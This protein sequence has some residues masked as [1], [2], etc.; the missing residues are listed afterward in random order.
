MGHWVPLAGRQGGTVPAVVLSPIFMVDRLA[1]AATYAGIFRSRDGGSSWEPSNEGLG[2]YMI[3]SIAFSPRYPVDHTLYAGAADGGVYRST[4]SGDKW[5][6]L[7]RLGSGSAVTDLGVALGPGDK[8]VSVLAGTLADGVFFSHDGWEW[9]TCNSA[10]ADLSVIAVGVSPSYN[11]DRTAL[12]A[13]ARGLSMTL[14]GGSKWSQVWSPA[15]DDGVQCIALSPAFAS[16]R[17][18]FAGTERLGVIRSLDGGATWQPANAGLA[19]LCVNALAI[20][21]DFASDGMLVAAT[22]GSVALSADR[23]ES[24]QLLK[25]GSESALSLAVSR[26]SPGVGRTILAGLANDGVIRSA[27]SGKNWAPA[28]EGLHASSLIGMALSPAF[29]ADSTLFAWG[30]S[31]GLLRS[32]DGGQGW[33]VVSAASD[34]GSINA[35]ALS[36]AFDTD[37]TLFAATSAG[38]FASED[39]GTEWQA[40]GLA[41]QDVNLPAL[42]PDFPHDSLIVAATEGHLQLSTDGG[43]NWRRLELPSGE[44]AALAAACAPG[45]D[46]GKQLLLASWREPSRSRRGRLRVWR[47]NLPDSPWTLLFSRDTATRITALAVPDS[48]SQDQQFYIGNGDAVYRTTQGAQERT[49]DG[50]TPLWLPSTIGSRSYPVL[51][52]A[53]SA[54]Y[55]QTH[56]MLA[57]TADGVFISQDDVRSWSKLGTTPGDRG[58][59][60]VALQPMEAGDATAYALSIG[61]QLWKWD[62]QD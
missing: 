47:R 58:A 4:D 3:Q 34:G 42:S 18:A 22:A 50:V 39:G 17:T 7:A 43:A 5:E 57:A 40:R 55:G 51:S 52:L 26:F 27:D 53:A 35:V 61:G 32:E 28:N 41:D 12:A 36:P 14:D 60:A 13:T 33:H 20:S 2:S 46:E 29:E 56:T 62:P 54:N 48:Y 15:G 11:E 8:E 9:K 19:G 37:R 45:Q 10:L 6:L 1:F 16:D 59:L 31:E 44:D 38:L 23:G 24:W 30:P 49:R 21:S 25:G